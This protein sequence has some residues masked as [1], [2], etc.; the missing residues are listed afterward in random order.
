MKAKRKEKA[1]IYL[2][3]FRR[4]PSTLPPNERMVRG[5]ETPAQS[6]RP[7]NPT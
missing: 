5:T 1:L 6:D 3:Y 4:Q 7:F 2:L